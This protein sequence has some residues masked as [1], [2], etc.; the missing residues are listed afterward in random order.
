M[1][2]AIQ[3]ASKINTSAIREIYRNESVMGRLP[4]SVSVLYIRNY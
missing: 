4:P 2:G 3:T 1:E